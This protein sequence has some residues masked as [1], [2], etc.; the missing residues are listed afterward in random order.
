LPPG[1]SAR[2]PAEIQERGNGS[3]RRTVAREPPVIVAMAG[4]PGV[5]KSAL[6]QALAGR[7][8]AVVLNKDRI[9][10]GLFPPSRVDYTREQDDFCLDVM[11][12]TTRWLLH[13]DRSTVVILDG[14]TYTRA[15]RVTALRELAAE[16]GAALRIIECTCAAEIALAR[17]DTDRATGGHPAAN[18]DAAL[19]WNLRAAADPI[20]EP[21]L[22]VDTARPLAT[23]VADC[24]PY[25]A[26]ARTS[27][28]SATKSVGAE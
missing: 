2:A 4:L 16:L 8:D 12:R 5:G 24:V 6:A 3:F 27:P 15:Y 13:R 28:K 17:I 1:P 25:L 10:A 14:S 22:T 26:A 20:G 21:K 9:R 18:R 7:F 11:H 23:C 19:Y